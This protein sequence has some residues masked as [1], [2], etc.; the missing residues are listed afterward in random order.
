MC[1]FG[2][3][4]IL[5][6]FHLHLHLGNSAANQKLT[7]DETMMQVGK[8]SRSELVDMFLSLFYLIL[9]WICAHE[10][11][12]AAYLSLSVVQFRDFRFFRSDRYDFDRSCDPSA[13][14]AANLQIGA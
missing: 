9:K 5:I 2:N 12:M 1:F 3:F 4:P 6:L 8:L 10:L 11:I 7:N 14:F 13:V